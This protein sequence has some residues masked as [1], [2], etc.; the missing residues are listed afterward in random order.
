MRVFRL[1]ASLLVLCAL[2]GPL[3][4][5]AGAD[6]AASL[7]DPGRMFVIKLNLPQA[8]IDA[9][10]ADRDKYQPG[11]LSLAETDG[12]PAGVGSFSA[13]VNIKLKLKGSASYRPLSEKSAFKIKFED[14]PFRGLR[15]MTLN[16]MVEDP[17]MIH[18]TLAYTAFR[19]AGVPASR[20]GYAYVYVNGEDFGIHLD[21][22]ALDEIALSK[23]F[24][25][26]FDE[27][28]QHLY[29]GENE[30]DTVPGRVGWYEVDEGLPDRSDLQALIDAVNSDGSGD[31]ATRVADVADLA[32]MTR[33]WAAEKYVGQWDGYAGYDGEGLPNNYYLYSDSS[34]R[35]QMMPWGNDESWQTWTR[36]RVPFGGGGGEMFN[37]CLDD[38]ACSEIYRR[39]VIAV[40]DAVA[41]MHLDSLAVKTAA[42]LAPWQ[43]LE[44]QESTRE[45]HD[46]EEIQ[47]VVDDA[48]E[49]IAARPGEVAEWLGESPDSGEPPAEP[50]PSDPTPGQGGGASSNSDSDPHLQIRLPRRSFEAGHVWFKNGI[51]RT[52]VRAKRHGVFTQRVTVQTSDGPVLACRKRTRVEQPGSLTLRC[53]LL[54]SVREQLEQGHPGISVLIRFRSGDGKA[55][56]VVRRIS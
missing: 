7:F 15:V 56:S 47:N 40:R 44:R 30:A 25:S 4:A 33:M 11:T 14:A 16:N 51:L 46:A 55:Q 20:T 38:D 23:I 8:S 10:A 42:M 5:S 17:S 21:I 19:G 18:E 26:T 29:E 12:T 36:W 35:F 34:G 9:L 41:T 50:G 28:T 48:R 6:E 27:D 3:A 39:A 45:E 43:A 52:R 13:P 54:D 2:G 22:E 32:E 31:W 49:F 53:R 1:L 37:R 24:G